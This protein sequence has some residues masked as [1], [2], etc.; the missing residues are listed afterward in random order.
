M[1]PDTEKKRHLEA[2][3]LN[4]TVSDREDFI[5]LGAMV[6]ALVVWLAATN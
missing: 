3:A 6:I 1:T 5:K 2:V 4:P